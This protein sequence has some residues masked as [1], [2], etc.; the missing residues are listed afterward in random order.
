MVKLTKLEKDAL[1]EITNMCSFHASMAL[2]A[3]TGKAVELDIK[4]KNIDS[5]IVSLGERQQE[6]DKDPV[7]FL[8]IYSYIERGNIDGNIVITFKKD[9]ALRLYDF[10]IKKQVGTTKLVDDSVRNVLSELGN[11][12]SGQMLG[13]LNRSLGV[14]A[15]H[16]VPTIVH[17]FGDHIYDYVYFN[18]EDKNKRA[19]II[20][21]DTKFKFSNLIIDG[22]IMLLLSHKSF[23]SLLKMI[24]KMSKG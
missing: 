3:I 13:V 7:M 22:Q 16:S 23:S 9:T 5:Y 8:G 15:V 17:S 21:V 18:I 20:N 6:S 19:I 24:D 4:S 10:M 11:M 12:V 2:E 1:N 14:E